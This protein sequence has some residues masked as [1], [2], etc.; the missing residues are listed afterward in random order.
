MRRRQIWAERQRAQLS[1]VGFGP[2]DDIT[3]YAVAVMSG[4]PPHHIT[5]EEPKKRGWPL[6]KKRGPRK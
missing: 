4:E 2:N 6:G 1:P 3:P 5:R